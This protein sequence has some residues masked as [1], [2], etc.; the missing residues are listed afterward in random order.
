MFDKTKLNEDE[1]YGYDFFIQRLFKGSRARE[2]EVSDDKDKNLKAF[3]T[4]IAHRDFKNISD[5]AESIYKTYKK[6]DREDEVVG[7]VN[8]L[9]S[10]IA[11]AGR[12][13]LLKKFLEDFLLKDEDDISIPEKI[14]KVEQIMPLYYE[15]MEKRISGNLNCFYFGIKK[16]DNI[17]VGDFYRFLSAKGYKRYNAIESLIFK[18]KTIL[19]KDAGISQTDLANM[20]IN[21]VNDFYE[22][23][24]RKNSKYYFHVNKDLAL[25]WDRLKYFKH[26]L[27]NY[28]ND[29]TK[30]YVSEYEKKIAFLE[31]D[32][33][34]KEF[35]IQASYEGRH[36]EFYIQVRDA[37]KDIENEENKKIIK[38][39]L[40][41]VKNV[42]DAL[43]STDNRY[44]LYPVNYFK[45]NT[46]DPCHFY[47][48][49]ISAIRILPNEKELLEETRQLMVQAFNQTLKDNNY[50]DEI[51][52]VAHEASDRV[53][54]AVKHVAK[55]IGFKN[56]IA[57]NGLGQEELSNIPSRVVEIMREESLPLNITCIKGVFDACLNGEKA[58]YLPNMS[59]KSDDG[60]EK[61]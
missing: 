11:L 6:L 9:D 15:I 33:Q 57:Q 16:P 26:H 23:R 51:P 41:K 22:I 24:G 5:L 37:L 60:V 20:Y 25:I 31:N 47:N 13:S 44:K 19:S 45:V 17:F 50:R 59:Q 35:Y 54:D 30:A 61:E 10:K 8:L 27:E 29:E 56:I 14:T 43:L 42:K 1:R 2:I 18:N 58:V 3:L 40:N 48:L 46:M 49:I 34:F 28:M 4:Y 21:F 32:Y 55:M 7:Y 52:F 12:H 39:F 38:Q 53:P 36:G